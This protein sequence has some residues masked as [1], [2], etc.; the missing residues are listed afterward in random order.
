MTEPG[1]REVVARTRA[2]YNRNADEYATTTGR[3]AQFPGLDRELDRFLDAL[4]AGPVLDLGCGA[5]RD[6]EYLVHRGVT[7]ISG[8]L[9]ERL[10]TMTRLR[11]A[12]AGV[13][14]FDLTSLPFRDGVFA[15]V[16]ACASVL[17]IPRRH[18]IEAFREVHRVLLP[19]GLA[20]ISLKDGDEEAW[21]T[22]GRLSFPRWFSLRKPDSVVRE[23]REAGFVRA[24]VH[25][26]GRGTWFIAEAMKGQDPH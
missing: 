7:V 1:I 16:W 12:P 22:G 4:P 8:D 26:S 25:P 13:V 11:C 23:L 24:D 5:G 20:A 18:H 2:T 19:D 9:S 17:H 21:M 3:L 14:Q 15:G 6:T 10:L